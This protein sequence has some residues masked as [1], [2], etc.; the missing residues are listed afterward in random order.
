MVSGTGVHQ[1]KAHHFFLNLRSEEFVPGAVFIIGVAEFFCRGFPYF[2]AE[3]KSAAARIELTRETGVGHL[4]LQLF[5]AT[6]F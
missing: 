3:K 4:K 1:H 6:F 2:G 5:P